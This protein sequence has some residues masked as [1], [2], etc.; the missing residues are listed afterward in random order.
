MTG[1]YDRKETASSQLRTESVELG[2]LITPL[3]LMKMTSPDQR[4]IYELGLAIV[5][6]GDRRRVPLYWEDPTKVDSGAKR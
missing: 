6:L 4:E 3:G 2:L 1:N 5:R